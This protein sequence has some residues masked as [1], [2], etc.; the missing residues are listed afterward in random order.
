LVRSRSN[1]GVKVATPVGT[2]LGQLIFGFLAD[3]VGRKRM[4]G[5]ELMIIVVATFAQALLGSA[6]SVNIIGA[7]VV[8]R[9]IVSQFL[10][11]SIPPLIIILPGGREWGS[12]VT[13]LCQL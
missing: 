13:A 5:V 11:P 9:G 8:W 6:A 2:L 4:Y 7:I 10:M 12:V 3:Q 1:L